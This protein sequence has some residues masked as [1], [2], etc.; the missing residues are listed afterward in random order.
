[1]NHLKYSDILRV[2]K[3]LEDNINKSYNIS[4]LS[5]VIVHQA[6]DIIEYQ[7]RHDGVNANVTLGVFDNIIQE[8]QKQKKMDATIIFWEITNLVEGLQYKIELLTEKE[9]DAIESKMKSEVAFVIKN[10]VKILN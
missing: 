9:I 5:N 8:S 6:K 1:M 4:L 2:N 10:L 7:F 3:E